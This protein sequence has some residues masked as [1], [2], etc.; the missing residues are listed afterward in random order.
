MSHAPGPA[1]GDRVRVVMTKWG[2][3]PHWEFE[4]TV[5]GADGHGEWL[6]VAE[7]TFMARPGASFVAPVDQVVLVPGGAAEDRGFLA[8]FYSLG[9]AVNIYVDMATPAEWVGAELHAVDLDL[10]VVQ[11]PSG[12][13]WVDDEDEFADHRV[14]FGYPDDIVRLA[15]S[16]RDRVLAAVEAGHPPYDGTA[17]RWLARLSPTRH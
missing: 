5:L 7:G 9:G 3:R 8:T 4:A 10:D 12:R 14:R 13:A 16:T 15:V 2:G 6:G 1:P 17:A 11:G